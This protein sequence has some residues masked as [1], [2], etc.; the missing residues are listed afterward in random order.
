MNEIIFQVLQDEIDGAYLGEYLLK[1]G[2]IVHGSKRRS[3]LYL[4]AHR[5]IVLQ[6]ISP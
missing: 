3:S 5:A 6:R 2:Y 1:Q 4:I